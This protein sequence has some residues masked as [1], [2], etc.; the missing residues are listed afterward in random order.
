MIKHALCV[1]VPVIATIATVQAQ[2]NNQV[3][4]SSNRG[5]VRNLSTAL[6]YWTIVV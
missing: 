4:F 1:P 3:D 5:A 2:Y 6:F